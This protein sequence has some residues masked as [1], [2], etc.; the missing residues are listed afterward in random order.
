MVNLLGAP[1]FEGPPLISGL[2]KILDLPDVSFHFY[3]KK[4]TRPMRK[5]GHVTILNDEIEQGIEIGKSVLTTLRIESKEE[6]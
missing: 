6:A 1:D 2:S 4:V 5:M 3:G